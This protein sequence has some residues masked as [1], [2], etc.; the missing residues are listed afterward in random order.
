MLCLC[1]FVVSIGK[2]DF[3]VILVC[4]YILFGN[5]GLFVWLLINVEDLVGFNGVG[6]YDIV[7]NVVIDIVLEVVIK[8]VWG[9]LWNDWVFVVCE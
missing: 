4:C 3:V 8:M 2:D 7:F 1:F 5:G 9:L 6:F